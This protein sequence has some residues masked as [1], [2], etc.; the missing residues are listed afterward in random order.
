MLYVNGYSQCKHWHWHCLVAI[1]G[2]FLL[3]II[4][5]TYR[6]ITKSYMNMC[7]ECLDITP[8]V[9]ELMFLLYDIMCLLHLLP[10]DVDLSFLFLKG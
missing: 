2:T 4:M 7:H 8:T 1:D 6:N 9:N 10:V 3:D 5:Y